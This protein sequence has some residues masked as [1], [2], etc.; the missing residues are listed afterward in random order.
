MRTASAHSNAPRRQPPR[1]ARPGRGRVARPSTTN[2]PL[3]QWIE[4]VS[5][6]LNDADPESRERGLAELQRGFD[7][8]PG[9]WVQDRHELLAATSLAAATGELGTQPEAHIVLAQIQLRQFGD[10]AGAEKSLWLAT[11]GAA[12][13]ATS[14]RPDHRERAAQVN[15]AASRLWGDLGNAYQ[16][17]A[18]NEIGRYYT[19]RLSAPIGA[20]PVL[21]AWPDAGR[22][23][24]SSRRQ[25]TMGPPQARIPKSPLLTIDNGTAAEPVPP[26]MAGRPV[27]PMT[28]LDGL[29][30]IASLVG[31]VRRADELSAYLRAV[32]SARAARDELPIPWMPR[33]IREFEASLTAALR[34]PAL[35]D[36]QRIAAQQ[37]RNSID[38]GFM[39]ESSI[40]YWGTGR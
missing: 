31:V 14:N 32:Q 11:F 18:R 2:E 26:K 17:D 25:P 1:P 30:L 27:R 6:L 38:L 12:R 16:R 40:A 3:S 15:R 35:T 19:S 29:I 5:T 36:E 39:L 4:M 33:A 9:P 20:R 28:K 7:F 22:P 13:L 24:T 37:V 23:E 10:R 8:T 21:R 34:N